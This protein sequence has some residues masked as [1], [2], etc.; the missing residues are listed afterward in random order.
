MQSCES[1]RIRTGRWVSGTKP[2]PVIRPQVSQKRKN[3]H[4]QWLGNVVVIEVGTGV[5]PLLWGESFQYPL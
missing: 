4:S 3:W 5:H 2:I 1:S